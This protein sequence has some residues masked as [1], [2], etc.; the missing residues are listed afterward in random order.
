VSVR[1]AGSYQWPVLTI[2]SRPS[3]YHQRDIFYKHHFEREADVSSAGFNRAIK[4]A[5]TFCSSSA[6][7][8]MSLGVFVPLIYQATTIDTA[9]EQRAVLLRWVIWICAGAALCLHLSVQA[10]VG[11][12]EERENPRDGQ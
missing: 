12:L 9:I 7:A 2:A 10:I 4:F 3:K 5:A 11:L 6:V 8:L 1:G